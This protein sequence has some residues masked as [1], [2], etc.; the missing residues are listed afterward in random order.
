MIVFVRAKLMIVNVVN[1]SKFILC[2]SCWCRL[3]HSIASMFQ[4]NSNKKVNKNTHF[5]RN[6]MQPRCALT[7]QYRSC[8]NDNC[9]EKFHL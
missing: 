2:N 4:Q 8:K 5:Q 7:I 6:L 3:Q 9:I 1:F